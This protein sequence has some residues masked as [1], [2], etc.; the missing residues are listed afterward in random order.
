[1]S[2]ILKVKRVEVER[3]GRASGFALDLPEK[4]FVVLHGPNESGKTSLATALAWLI[5]G[6]GTEQLLHR[7]GRSDEVL[8]A[9]LIGQ[10]GLDDL[11]IKVKVRVPV[12]SS[13][14]IAKGTFGASV[15]GAALNREILTARLGGG[16]FDGYRRLYWVQALEVANGSNLQEHVSVQ[17]VFGGINPFAEA[18]NLSKRARE[19]LGAPMGRA[20][21]ST[22]RKLH[23]QCEGLDSEQGNLSKARSNWATFE[24]QL[25]GTDSRR[26]EVERRL[27]DVGNRL[28]SLQLALNALDSGLV[29]TRSV[30]SEEL[31][32]S[33]EPTDKD[34]FLHA[35]TTL[36]RTR[37]G[38]LRAAQ[39]SVRNA[40]RDYETAT[41]KAHADWRPLIATDALGDAGIYNIDQ[42]EA[43]LKSCLKQAEILEAEQ[44]SYSEHHQE[45]EIEVDKLRNA[46]AQQGPRG[47]TPE[48]AVEKE[49]A[50]GGELG[51]RVRSGRTAETSRFGRLFGIAGS[52]VAT[53]CAMA[54]VVLAILRDDWTISAVAGA[55]A[56]ALLIATYR[57]V[58][59][60]SGSVE[61]L[62]PKHVE[63]AG[64]LLSTCAERDTANKG[65]TEAKNSLTKQNHLA[66]TTQQQYRRS[67][68]A[69]GVHETLVVRFEPNVVQHLKAVHA[70]QSAG[71][72]VTRA[73]QE[74]AVQLNEVNALFTGLTPD[75]DAAAAL[76]A[77]GS[78]ETETREAVVATAP[79]SRRLKPHDDPPSASISD[80][81]EAE[82]LLDAACARVDQNA[83]AARAV[84]KAEDALMRAIK[85]D[86]AAL[87]CI[88]E[89][90]PDDLR[91]EE[92]QLQA[93][94]DDLNA[95]LEE[96]KNQI[97]DLA[98]QK[99]ALEAAENRAA[100]LT[101]E[102]GALF[103]QIEE[104]LVSGLAHHL[105]AKLL[106]D[107]AERH[108]TKQQPGLL[109]RTQELACEVADWT[110]VTVNPHA[111]TAR[112]PAGT[113]NMLVDGPRGE[114][115]DGRLSLGAQTLLY[116]ALRL[117]TVEEQ[118]EARRVRLPLMLDDV[119]VGLDDDR[120]ERCL[121]V[122]GMFAE[123]HQM[124]LLT[125]HESTM[126]R[127]KAAGAAVLTIP[128]ALQ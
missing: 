98:V 55:G 38:D 13:R 29:A 61:P 88:E 40:E 5:A 41:N 24:A 64:R 20:S 74:E 82:A 89:S 96:I 114:H 100:E 27:R 120:A 11:M 50:T 36:V 53:G 65:L 126:Q 58:R 68:A 35:H 91:A 76:D 115:S 48:Q 49:E 101:L 42:A 32:S 57:M 34:R 19:L 116:L 104:H 90:K 33:P 59:V 84:Q 118:A 9:K 94:R 1:M 73:K 69:L 75:G 51:R 18:D 23:E 15:G 117:A 79:D 10:L 45:L 25:D 46:W 78:E 21:P 6:P 102:R 85:H 22:A 80:A 99:R 108:R 3:W 62:D 26:E 71:A 54:V 28:T 107:A 66:S 7:F 127:A 124:I 81:T 52:L 14:A 113:D 109:S 93:S 97:T 121:E 39:N 31:A 106:R 30:K 63:L 86:D 119:L 125:C 95:E 37:I 8:E 112:R 110:N 16:D 72:D 2:D 44:Q 103:M 56:T 4:G 105:A 60:L 92:S 43:D 67:L 128:P 122:L 12:R 17:A 83:A 87:S 123:R 70:A 111:P 77:A 47:L